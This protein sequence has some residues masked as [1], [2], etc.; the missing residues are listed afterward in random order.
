MTLREKTRD[1]I[2]AQE[3]AGDGGGEGSN[4]EQIRQSANDLLAAGDAA[5]R[6]ALSGDSERFL[7]ANRQHGG[8]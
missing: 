7:Q 2:T 5:I 4:L 6:R 1:P 3:R 8:Q